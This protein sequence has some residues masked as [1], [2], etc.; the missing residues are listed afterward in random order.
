MDEELAGRLERIAHLEA[1]LAPAEALFQHVLAR[2]GQAVEDVATSI[3]RHWGPRAP[4]LGC[5]CR[6]LLIRRAVTLGR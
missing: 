3:S 6:S 5:L 1:L 4:N 2:H